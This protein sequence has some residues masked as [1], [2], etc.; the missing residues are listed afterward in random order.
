MKR[1][2]IAAIS[3][4]LITA[5]CGGAENGVPDEGVP[6]EQESRA[7]ASA[8]ADANRFLANIDADSAYVYANL[9]RLPQ[10]VVDKVWAM[11]EASANSNRAIFDALA[12]DEEVS[13]EVR[14]LIDQVK[15]LSTRE[16]WEAAG[17]HANP[18]YAF[19]G[20]DLMPFAEFELSDGAAFSEFLAGIESELEQ[21]LQ[22]RD[23]EGVEVIWFEIAEGF[24]VAMQHDEDSVTVAV[25]PDDAVMLARVAGQYEP[26][27]AMS[28]D[29]L[30]AFNREI[31]FSNHGSGFLDWRRIVNSLMTGDAALARLAHGDESFTAIVENPACVAEYQAVTEALPRMVFGYTRLT[32][33]HADLLVRQETSSELASGLAPIARAPVSIDREL[34]GLFNFGLAFDLVAGREFA[35][36]LVDGW[37]VNPPQCPSF[38]DIAAQAPQMQETLNR[39]IPPVVTNLNGLFLEAETLSLGENGI[40]TGGGTLSFFMR[41]PQLLL[42]MAQM[43]SPAVAELQLEPGS[44]PQP[45]PEG[46]IPQLQQLDLKAWL[47]MGENAI[48]IAIGEDNV[49]ALTRAIQATSADDLLMSG[50]FDFDMLVD[51]VDMAEATLGDVG[52]EEAAMGLEA[53]RAQY[54][55][56]AEI[57]DQA[58]FKIR[59]GDKGID[60]VAE[61]TLN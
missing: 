56:L 11:N 22:R 51:L 46:A 37:V 43:F 42:G 60:F 19:Y 8:S 47:A 29:T 55:A 36:G 1:L 4:V 17:L 7:A 49:D 6:D 13:A 25:I 50:R 24:G 40:P 53:Q 27:S 38:A 10:Q 54:E 48:G 16:G 14:A 33:S 57:Y 9:E 32:E 26:A 15:A 39:P 59:L 52:G 31:G 12:E 21:P 18:L 2:C 45:V 20:A 41:N 3:A 5:G 34:S 44:E 23:I 35:R 61:S 28:S 30:E 58:S